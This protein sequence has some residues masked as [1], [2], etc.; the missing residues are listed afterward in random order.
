MPPC[1]ICG[2]HLLLLIQYEC[3]CMRSLHDTSDQQNMLPWETQ[4]QLVSYV[5]APPTRRETCSATATWLLPD[6][7]LKEIVLSPVH[8]ERHVLPSKEARG[9]L[10]CPNPVSNSSHPGSH[11][12]QRAVVSIDEKKRACC[13][14]TPTRV[15]H[16]WRQ[17]WHARDESAAQPPNT[18]HR[19]RLRP[20]TPTGAPGRAC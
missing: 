7:A 17:R 1:T 20:D 9:S 13:E 10:Q 14:V 11:L 6:A 12:R 16:P 18:P 8:L 5:Y 3:D 4:E 2:P 15:G 19:C